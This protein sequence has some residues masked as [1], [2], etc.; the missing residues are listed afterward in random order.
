M[1]N[2]ISLIPVNQKK[3]QN[4]QHDRHY[5]FVNW[6][7]DTKKGQAIIRDFGKEKYGAPRSSPIRKPGRKLRRNNI[8]TFHLPQQTLEMMKHMGP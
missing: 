5:A 8:L 2:Y 1:L 6:L 4:S 7:T 3:I